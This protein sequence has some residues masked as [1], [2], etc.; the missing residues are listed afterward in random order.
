MQIPPGSGSG[1]DHLQ[2]DGG[3]HAVDISL[4][5]LPAQQVDGLAKPL[6]MDDLPFPEELDDIVDI[7]II[8]QPQDVVIGDPGL[9][10]WERIA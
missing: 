4:I 1:R 3:V 8:A 5:Q 6:E 7:G 10:L 2:I 9:L